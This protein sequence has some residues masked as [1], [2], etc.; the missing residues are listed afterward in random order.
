MD[1]S[2]H[3]IRMEQWNAIVLQ[4]QARPERQTAASWLTENGVDAKQ[5]FSWLR[6][7]RQEAY[8]EMKTKSL[9]S[10][11]GM[12]TSG[13]GEITFAEI[14]VLSNGNTSPQE[15]MN[16]PGFHADAFVRLGAAT[17][18]PNDQ[19]GSPGHKTYMWVYRAGEFDKNHP[20]VIYDYQRGRSHKHPE[21]FLKDFN[22]ILE[23]WKQMVFSSITSWTIR[24]TKLQTRTAGFT[25]EEIS[26]MRS[27]L[28]PRRISRKPGT[29]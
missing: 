14:T 1:K 18:D 28:L 17:I 6:Q 27:K 20:I 5:Y 13:S 9:S 3:E 7:I 26:Q 24:W 11:R 22:G 10:G 4:C 12:G 8:S 29:R 21:E 23:S 15:S 2:T 16:P 19:K 25:R